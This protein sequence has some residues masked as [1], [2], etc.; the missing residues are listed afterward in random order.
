MQSHFRNE[1]RQSRK[2]A[3]RRLVS[4]FQCTPR[5]PEFINDT[6]WPFCCGDLAEFIGQPISQEQCVSFC[7]THHFWEGAEEAEWDNRDPLEP[8]L[9]LYEFNF[10]ACLACPKK[11]WV[12]QHT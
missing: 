5:I 1:D 12:W 7:R 6:D 2:I 3:R 4:A 8:P 10:F 9:E 11:Y